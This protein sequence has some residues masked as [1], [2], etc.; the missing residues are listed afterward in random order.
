MVSPDGKH[1][2]PI[3]LTAIF[4]RTKAAYARSENPRNHRET[5]FGPMESRKLGMKPM[6]LQTFQ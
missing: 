4:L 3:L 2:A 6:D 1:V 5:A